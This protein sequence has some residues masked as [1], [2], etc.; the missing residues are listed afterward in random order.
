MRKNSWIGIALVLL[1]GAGCG[2]PIGKARPTAIPTRPANLSWDGSIGALLIDRCS[3]CHGN[4]AGI[5]YSTYESALRGG[6][7]GPVILPGDP[8]NS[9][10]VIQQTAGNHPGQLSAAEL[11]RVTAWIKWGAPEK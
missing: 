7:H 6:M 9:E 4:V 1:L 11:A 8:A 2:S 10:V 3:S 5:S